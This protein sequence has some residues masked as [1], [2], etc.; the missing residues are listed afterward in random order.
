MN[1]DRWKKL[2]YGLM[3]ALLLSACSQEELGEQGTALP[4][5]EYPL[6]IG[7]VSLTAEVSEQPWTRMAESTDGMG[8]EFKAGDAIG[9]SL[10]GETATYTYD[11]NTWTSEAPLYWKD[12][13]PVTVGWAFRSGQHLPGEQ[14]WKQFRTSNAGC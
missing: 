1:K 14:R 11:G 9:V 12:K 3:A 13:E 7:S 8:S 6:Q 2:M 4:E 10:N 5:S